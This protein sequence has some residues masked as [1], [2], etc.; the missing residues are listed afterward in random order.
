MT[1]VCCSIKECG[2]DLVEIGKN[3]D[4]ECVRCGNE[5]DKADAKC[6]EVEMGELYKR[7]VEIHTNIKARR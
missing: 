3:H 1:V 7:L 2:S 4:F 6:K 5:F